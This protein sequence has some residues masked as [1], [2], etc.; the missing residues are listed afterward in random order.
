MTELDFVITRLEALDLLGEAGVV[1]EL[2][3]ERDHYKQLITKVREYLQKM[4]VL[5]AHEV[6]TLLKELN[7]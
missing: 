5:T 2:K 4:P 6:G 1:A 7:G 3:L